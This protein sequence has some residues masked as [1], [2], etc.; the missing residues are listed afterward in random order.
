MAANWWLTI[1]L[2]INL[3]GVGGYDLYAYF[4]LTPED[5][6]SF[7]VQGW[8]K[9]N[10]I[11]GVALGILLGHLGWPLSRGPIAKE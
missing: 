9:S 3:V 10:P 11:L 4:W 1:W 6:V 2:V 5:T 8:L 7:V